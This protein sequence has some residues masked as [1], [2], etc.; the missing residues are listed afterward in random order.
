MAL[1]EA[2]FNLRR[3][4]RL[5]HSKFSYDGRFNTL[6]QSTLEGWY[7]LTVDDS[8]NK[9]IIWHEATVLK[10]QRGQSMFNAGSGK[11]GIIDSYPEIVTPIIEILVNM[12]K[13]WKYHK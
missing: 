12:K 1:Q 2:K 11:L 13:N 5:L 8:G 4:V 10:V 7:S 3:A 9:G 6:S